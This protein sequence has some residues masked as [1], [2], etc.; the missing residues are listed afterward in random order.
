MAQA[1]QAYV[2]LCLAASAAESAA[3][4]RLIICA[5]RRKYALM[6]LPSLPATTCWNPFGYYFYR[7]A[8]WQP[9]K[10]P[11]IEV[12]KV[13]LTI[14]KR[15]GGREEYCRNRDGF[16]KLCVKTQFTKR[17]NLLPRVW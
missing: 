11:M 8:F 6:S 10:F 2:L 7:V 3:T 5:R 4:Y 12:E 9:G 16:R 17:K 15:T 1:E 14:W 13:R